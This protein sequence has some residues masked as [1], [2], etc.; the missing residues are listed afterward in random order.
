MYLIGFSHVG[1]IGSMVVPPVHEQ[2][3]VQVEWVRLH[4]AHDAIRTLLRLRMQKIMTMK[5]DTLIRQAF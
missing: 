5:D 3:G 4:I 1:V 2:H